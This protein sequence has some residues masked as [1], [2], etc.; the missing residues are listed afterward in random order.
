MGA[1]IKFR[2][3]ENF[4]RFSHICAT[5]KYTESMTTFTVATV[6]ATLTE[7]PNLDGNDGENCHSNF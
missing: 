6:N 1:G 4:V 5:M 3:L 2:S 7:L